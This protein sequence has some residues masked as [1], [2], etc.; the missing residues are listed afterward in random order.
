[1][2]APGA[3]HPGTF[4]SGNLWAC[5]FPKSCGYRVILG[6]STAAWRSRGS[7]CLGFCPGLAHVTLGSDE[8]SGPA[9]TRPQGTAWGFV[10]CLCC[11][12]ALGESSF[13]PGVL[14]SSAAAGLWVSSTYTRWISC[15]SRTLCLEREVITGLHSVLPGFF[16]RFPAEFFGQMSRPTDLSA[17]SLRWKQRIEQRFVCENCIFLL[18]K[19][20][21]LQGLASPSAANAVT[22]NFDF[23]LSGSKAP[24]TSF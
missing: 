10:S 14:T 21:L 18:F 23:L 5:L 22:Q 2:T 8:R 17:L 20:L 4:C 24:H 6:V 15:F 9:V 19:I 13:C 12:P 1:M 11:H 16:F 3:Q 7:G